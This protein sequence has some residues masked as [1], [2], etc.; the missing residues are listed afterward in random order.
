MASYDDADEH[1]YLIAGEG[2]MT[3]DGKDQPLQPGWFTA[4]PRNTKFAVT[5]KG[6]NPLVLLSVIAGRPCS[7]VDPP[8]VTRTMR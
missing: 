8:P 4:I 3:L 2:M 5:K 1:L 7:P 6:R